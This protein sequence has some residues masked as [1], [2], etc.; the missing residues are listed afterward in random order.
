MPEQKIVTCPDKRLFTFTTENS[1]DDKT[2][3]ARLACQQIAP[4]G[5]GK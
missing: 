3:S 2:K 1:I 4:S 5:C